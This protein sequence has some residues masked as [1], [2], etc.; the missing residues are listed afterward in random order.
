[1]GTLDVAPSFNVEAF[2][3]P[4]CGA[5]SKMS[6]E[7]LLSHLH[8]EHYTSH[9]G[10]SPVYVAR[11]EYCKEDA[12]WLKLSDGEAAEGRMLIPDSSTA[13]MPHSN[14]PEN[15]RYDYEEARLVASKS[16]RSSAA[17]LRLAIQKLCIELGEKGRNVND[18]IASLVKKGLPVEIQQALDIVRVVGNNAVHPGELSN[19]DVSEISTGLF[20]LVN[21]IVEDRISRPKKLQAMFDKLPAG[22][23]EAIQKRDEK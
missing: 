7:G 8:Q 2:N 11:C 4:Y 12:F 18:D 14:M 19:D 6:W 16:P 22:A 15:V 20:E 3:C 21:Q 5:F 9:L 17:L 1:M 13:P 10:T 23:R